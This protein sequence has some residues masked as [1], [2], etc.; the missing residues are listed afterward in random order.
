MIIEQ[1]GQQSPNTG[2]FLKEDSTYINMA[3]TL[4]NALDPTG[5]I[6]TSDEVR[7]AIHMGDAY[8][9]DIDNVSSPLAGST[10]M[11]LMGIT[12][13]KQIHFDSLSGDFQK[14]GIRIT[15]YE[16][17]TTTAN[18]TPQTSVNMNFAS[19]KTA[20]ISIFLTPTITSNGTYKTSHYFPL[21]GNGVNVSP[22]QGDIAAG[23][24]LKPNTKY[25]FRIENTDTASC[26]FGL[27]FIWHDSNIVL[28]G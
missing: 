23:R 9:F 16:A 24:V 21:T 6:Q 12:G 7:N 1:V 3:D 5:S 28:G 22:V 27:N 8:S 25:L 18:G 4:A 17:P 19:T 2:R 14:G 13:S 15:L 11:Y 26:I 10:S 20:S